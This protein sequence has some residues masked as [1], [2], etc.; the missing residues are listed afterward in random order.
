MSRYSTRN[1][2]SLKWLELFQIC[3]RKGSLQATASE[4]GLSI[5]TVSHHIRR[6][7][8]H[9]GIELF[10]HSRRP[11]VLT[12]K[13][14]AFLKNIDDALQSIRKAK[15]EASAGN[16]TEASYL[17]IGSIEDF[18]S[19]ITPDLAV[20]LSE[21]MPRCNFLY[22]TGSSLDIISKL[23]DRH[24]DMGIATSPTDR[25]QSLQDRP[26]FRDPYIV[27]LP[28]LSEQSLSEIVAGKSKLPFLQF[29]SDL[30]IAQ[31]IEAQLRR[32]GLTLPN[33]FECG[34]NQMLMAM[35][36]AGAGWTI[37]TPLLFSRAQR[38]QSKLE[39]HPFP[40][41]S[42][43]R[44]LSLISSADCSQSILKLVE[45]KV[46]TLM[47]DQII[48]PTCARTPWLKEHFALIE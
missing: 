8:D 17:R 37:T 23:Q 18:E 29:S 25:L 2:L 36:A 19:D 39:M 43:A 46:R 12:P 47:T 11:M 28:K 27:V 32:L 20:F 42:F 7:E 35:V 13:G 34:N 26:M 10:D 33:K 9:L 48:N 31:Q 41:K 30:L 3:A 4:T 44:T 21:K 15:A 1:D 6:L 24:L 45:Q 40:G 22:Q 38:F 16:I 5:S 14:H